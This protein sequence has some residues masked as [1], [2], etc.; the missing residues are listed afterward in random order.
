[1]IIGMAGYIVGQFVMFLLVASVW[2]I[3][4]KLIRPLRRRVGV[5][6]GVAMGL[7]AFLALAQIGVSESLLLTFVVAVAC[8]SI[9][10]W[11]YRRDR[12]HR[13]TEAKT[14]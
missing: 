4:T 6:Y 14:S 8:E 11:Q 10:F 12:A 1:M 3:I 13:L 5:S 7:V 9:L 2:L